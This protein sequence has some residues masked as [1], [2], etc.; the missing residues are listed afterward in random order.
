M[1]PRTSGSPS[2]RRGATPHRRSRRIDWAVFDRWLDRLVILAVL[3]A[4][5]VGG[6]ALILSL[7]L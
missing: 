6:L 4:L 1:S 2:R 3:T 7:I 5:V